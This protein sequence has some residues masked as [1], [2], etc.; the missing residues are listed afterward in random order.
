MYYDVYIGNNKNLLF[1]SSFF[2]IIVNIVIGVGEQDSLVV[3]GAW[4]L[5]QRSEVRSPAATLCAAV[6]VVVQ[7]V[8]YKLL[9]LIFTVYCPIS[10]MRR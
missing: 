10:Q 8:I 6:M 3:N 5:T 7:T 9:K 1:F 2:V 4:L